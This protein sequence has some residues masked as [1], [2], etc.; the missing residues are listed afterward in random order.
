MTVRESELYPGPC[1][2]SLFG[3]DM[4]FTG[5]A[6]EIPVKT[7]L[8]HADKIKPGILM[9]A[10]LRSYWRRTET[11]YLPLASYDTLD[12]CS[13]RQL[14]VKSLPLHGEFSG[15]FCNKFSKIILSAKTKLRGLIILLQH[16]GA[17]YGQT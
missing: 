3:N 9:A 12:L 14:A 13:S 15:T 8:G 5:S 1:Y 6:L 4:R 17:S 10:K 16:R 11:Q 2:Q 7:M